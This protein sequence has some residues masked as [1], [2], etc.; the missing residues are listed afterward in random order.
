M[1]V[2]PVDAIGI[3]GVAC[4]ALGCAWIYP[5]LGL[6]ALGS[7]LLTGAVV[8]SRRAKPKGGD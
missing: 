2:E 4:V 8:A 7:L 1:K 3:A 5:P 6:I